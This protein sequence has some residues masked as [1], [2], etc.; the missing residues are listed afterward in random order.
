MAKKNNQ[1]HAVR[2]DSSELTKEANEVR[3][4][5][6]AMSKQVQPGSIWYIISQT[7]ITKWQ[8]YVGFEQGS[9][10][11]PERHPGEI[12]NQP[13]VCNVTKDDNGHFMSTTVPEQGNKDK[14][15]NY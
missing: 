1:N 7:W 4:L 15:M 11:K 3:D 9:E 6:T 13:L 2:G 8:T 5:L 12:Q 10:P 14:N